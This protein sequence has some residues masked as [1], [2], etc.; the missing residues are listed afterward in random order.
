VKTLYNGNAAHVVE[1]KNKTDTSN[2]RDSWN[3][4]KNA[5]KECEE[6]RG[7]AENG[8]N[9]HSAHIAGGA[10]AKVPSF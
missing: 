3:H 6:H 7:V 9:G 4:L 1:F 5:Q 10:N 2:K 8:H